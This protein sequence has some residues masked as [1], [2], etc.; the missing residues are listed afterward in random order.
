MI[1][2]KI[3]DELKRID[4]EYKDKPLAKD[5][6][7]KFL[8]NLGYD[9]ETRIGIILDF[10]L[11]VTFNE[12][13]EADV[14]DQLREVYTE[15]ADLKLGLA[16]AFKEDSSKMKDLLKQAKKELSE[17]KMLTEILGMLKK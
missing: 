9:K 8:A 1:Q 2:S 13:K 5:V 7:E 12:P 15:I 10:V 4:S 17:G 11:D 16:E 6:M 14:F 3:Q